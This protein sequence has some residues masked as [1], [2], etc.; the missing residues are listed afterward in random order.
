VRPAATTLTLTSSANPATAGD[1]VVY[2]AQVSPAVDGGSITFSVNGRALP[3]CANIPLSGGYRGAACTIPSVTAGNWWVTASYSGDA[4]YSS[5][6]AGLMEVAKAAILPPSKSVGRKGGPGGKPGFLLTLLAVRTHATPHIYWFA[7]RSV[8]C[9]HKASAILV[10]I[11]RS[12]R[13]VRCGAT[14]M[15]A[16]RPVAVHR[17]Y[18]ISLEAVRYGRHHAILS[19]GPVYKLTLY[20]PGDEAHWTPLSGLRLSADQTPGFASGATGRPVF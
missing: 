8:S 3:G 15:L 18:R 2:T 17:S 6:S 5:S 7:A 11:G 10:A 4:S 9:Y 12:V 19:R 13:S 1:R 16:S 14:I 20:M